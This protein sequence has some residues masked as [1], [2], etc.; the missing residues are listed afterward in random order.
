MSLIWPLERLFE[1]P[2]KVE[3]RGRELE[4]EVKGSEDSGGDPP[5]TRAPPRF[6]C[7]V[8]DHESEDGSYCPDCLADTMRPA[9]HR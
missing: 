4:A 9:P 8:C 7:R 6:R 3:E 5:P 2:H 1:P